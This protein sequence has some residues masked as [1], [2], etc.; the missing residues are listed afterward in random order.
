MQKN[1][2]HWYDGWIY[3]RFI[4]PVQREYYIEAVRMMDKNA[5]VLDVA[6]ATGGFAFFASDK[7]KK[8]TGLDLS[9][10]NIKKANDLLK[11][12]GCKNIDF[13]HGNA[14]EL[15]EIFSWRF[16]HSFISFAL[17][18]MPSE[19]RENVLLEM[20][21]VS[22]NVIIADFSVDM[23]FNF[24]GIIS[25]MAEFF[26]GPDHFANFLDFRKSGGVSALLEKND[27]KII[28]R[29]KTA[30]NTSEIIMAERL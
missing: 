4:A 13:V 18:E 22:K 10:R 6:C 12:N 7:V 20:S 3:H 28:K 23:D 15:S 2:N 24:R 1:L 30:N 8:I 25:R 29:K 9:F 11:S 27:M 19:I 5:K 16:D 21:K 14:L 17:H 26:A